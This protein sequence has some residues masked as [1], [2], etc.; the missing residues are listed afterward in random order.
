MNRHLMVASSE[1]ESV[2]NLYHVALQPTTLCNLNCEYCYLPLRALGRFMAPAVADAVAEGI[3]AI[4]SAARIVWHAGEPLACGVARFTRLIRP[5][6]SP[7]CAPLVTHSLQTNATLVTRDWCDTFKAFGIEVG[8]SVD[9]PSLLSRRRRDWKGRPAFDRIV[10]GV[11]CLRDAGIPFA[12]IAVVGVSALSHAEEIYDFVH[13]LGAWFLGINIEESEGPHSA[14]RL[15][16]EAVQAFWRDLYRA[17]RA[18]PVM[19]VREF[20]RM[21]RLMRDV[22]SGTATR[23]LGEPE[24]FPSIGTNGDVVLL[25]PEFVDNTPQFVVG[26]VLR[27]PF[28]AILREGLDAGYVRDY[29]EG[30]RRC[31]TTCAYFRVCGGGSA[32]NRYFEHGTLRASETEYCRNRVQHLADALIRVLREEEWT[33]M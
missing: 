5:F 23:N 25:A 6:A 27:T 32:S 26:N 10:Q 1:R 13:E 8:V 4:G 24:L 14:E 19:Q 2:K 21:L 12:V 22:A 16:T 31:R 15:G 30:I 17:W 11:T 9:G 7:A 18:N 3:V 33:G 29:R 28:A 20:S